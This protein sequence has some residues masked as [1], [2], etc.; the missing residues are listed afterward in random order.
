MTVDDLAQEIRRVDGSN[1]LGAGQLA[2]ALMP[3]L[4]AARSAP[5]AGKAVVKPL[6]WQNYTAA[7]SF[8]YYSIQLFKPGAYL[9]LNSR[10]VGMFADEEAAIAAAQADYEQRILSALASVAPSGAEPIGCVDR[11]RQKYADAKTHAINTLIEKGWTPV[12]AAPQAIPAEDVSKLVERLNSAHDP[13]RRTNLY[14]EA[15]DALTVSEAEVTSLR[16]KLEEHRKAL[17]HVRAIISE[18]AMVG[19]N[20]LEGTWAERL[21]ASQGMTH[22]VLNPPRA[23]PLPEDSHH[24]R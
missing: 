14:R 21:Y 7:C 9:R 5:E 13:L 19:F 17:E 18:G 22:A 23:A 1:N 2:E 20:P 3:F 11:F 24:G 10:E 15:A 16:R 8:G 6:E 12:Y 4:S